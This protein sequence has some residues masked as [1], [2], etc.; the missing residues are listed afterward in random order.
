MC[1]K[2]GVLDLSGPLVNLIAFQN[3]NPYHYKKVLNGYNMGSI[4]L[5]SK[6]LGAIETYLTLIDQL[7][8]VDKSPAPINYT[9]S[10]VSKCKK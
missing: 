2:L 8:G 10:S 5:S 9:F 6:F 3:L 1:C 7:R 4:D